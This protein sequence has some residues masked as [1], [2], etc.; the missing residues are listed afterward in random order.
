MGSFC[1]Q[2]EQRKTLTI[3][4]VDRLDQLSKKP[5]NVITAG[6]SRGGT[7]AVAA[8]MRAFGLNMGANLHPTTHEDFDF[9]NLANYTVTD[10]NRWYSLI[11]DK[12]SK[13]AGWSLKL[14]AALTM[15]H[16]F[17]NAM[18]NPLYVIVVRNPF[19]VARS[20]V[21]RD[22]TYGRSM[23]DYFHGY[24]HAI[25]MYADCFR[26]IGMVKGAFAICEYEQ[27]L[28]KPEIFVHEFATLCNLTPS[29]EMLRSAVDLVS[30]PG[31]KTV[32]CPGVALVP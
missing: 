16:A 14:P 28:A 2:V 22:E 15:L 31:Y 1:M 19:S 18:P 24:S 5:F 21:N 26:D 25:A 20:L 4:G 12:A 6:S 7:S 27:I 29:E 3:F 10:Y 9:A 32:E 17:E 8:V 30:S 23:L 11:E 13:C